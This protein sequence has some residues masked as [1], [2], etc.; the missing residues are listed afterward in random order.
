M[1]TS[2]VS[3]GVVVSVS[4]TDVGASLHA[5]AVTSAAARA[6]KHKQGLITLP[7]TL[8]NGTMSYWQKANGSKGWKTV[9]FDGG[10]GQM[11]VARLG[12]KIDCRY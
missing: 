4:D 11:R 10:S 12:I 8:K 3:G 7:P 9:F 6:K 2:G 1:A 5:R